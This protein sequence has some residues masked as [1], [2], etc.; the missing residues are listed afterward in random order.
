MVCKF[1][2]KNAKGEVEEKEETGRDIQ[3]C[4][5]NF[6]TNN[7]DITWRAVMPLIL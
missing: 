3:D 1:Q 5:A 4:I 7:P 6:E 2:Y